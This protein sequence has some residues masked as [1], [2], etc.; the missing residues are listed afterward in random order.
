MKLKNASLPLVLFLLSQPGL[1]GA[2]GGGL[3]QGTKVLNAVSTWMTG[4]G[5]VIVTIALM[6]VGF[7]M[8]FQA[9]EWKDVAPVFWGGILIGGAGAFASLFITGG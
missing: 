4:I 9:A 5:I 6:F 1:A 2:K 8:V 7:R 3:E